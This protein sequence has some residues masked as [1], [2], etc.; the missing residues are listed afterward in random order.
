MN[1][2]AFERQNAGDW[3][4]LEQY[5]RQL[6][7]RGHA[8]VPEGEI[9]TFITLYRKVCGD[10]ARARTMRAAPRIADRLNRLVARVHLRLYAARKLPLGAVGDFLRRAFPRL[11]RREW[12]FVL[13]SALLLVLPAI[14][15]G[16]ATRSNPYLGHAFA[17][18]GYVDS[19]DEAFGETFGQEGRGSGLGALMTS[20]YISNNVQ[21]S[22][23]AFAL[24]IAFGLGT[25]Y[26]LVT[27]GATVG[28]IGAVVAQHGLAY[29]FWSFVSAHGGIELGAIVLSGAAGL[30]IGYALINP[31]KLRRVP[32][33]VEAGKTAG[34]MMFGVVGMLIV[35][36]IL[37]GF[38]S[39][40]P[41][42]NPIKI[43]FGIL[44]LAGMFAYFC[45][46][47]REPVARGPSS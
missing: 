45:S 47:R 41:L 11:I 2:R 3:D 19:M 39:P 25:A 15:A 34:Q 30:R 14:A 16:W 29:N 9:P 20:F 5:A 33:L 42:P 40:S 13:T 18:P 46:G 22:F 7:Q 1:E 23:F 24:G 36:A 28:G 31:G 4:R 27:N 35:A 8:G 43:A 38:V 6:E 26:V 10:L 44:M 12:P 17:P 37:E 21:V 32:A